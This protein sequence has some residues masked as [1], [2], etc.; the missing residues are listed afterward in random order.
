M[1]SLADL[2]ELLSAMPAPPATPPDGLPFGNRRDPVEELVYIV[3]TLMTRAQRPIAEAFAGLL[4]ATAGDMSRL[5]EV[6]LDELEDI[7]RPLGFVSRRS[8]QLQTISSMIAF[9]FD[10]DLDQLRHLP[11]Q[12]AVRA[13][14]GLPGVGVKTAKC[15]LMYCFDIPVLPV[16]IHVLRVAKRLGL[17]PMDASW[18]ES[19][20]L[21]EA[22]VPGELK[23]DTHVR[24]VHHGQQTCRTRAP[25]CLDCPVVGSCP[26]AFQPSERRSDYVDP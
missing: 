19:D 22:G 11:P 10:G 20:L 7:V 17:I 14:A 2:P 16:D 9:E 1:A 23:Y 8:K 18:V 15:V 12:E 24:F 4:A 26:V 3:L 13:L 6:P 25:R 5:H 21:L